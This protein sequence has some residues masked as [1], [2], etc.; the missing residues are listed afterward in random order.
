M[1][2]QHGAVSFKGAPLST[3]RNWQTSITS[4]LKTFVASNTKGGT[5]RRPGIFDWN[6]TFGQYGGVP[7]ALPGDAGAFIGYPGPEDGIV[8]SSG[9]CA[10]GPAMIQ[11]LSTTWNWVTDEIVSTVYNMVGTGPL[12]ANSALVQDASTPNTTRSSA[13]APW[14]FTPVGGAVQ[15]PCI[16]QATLN[17]LVN[18]KEFA[19]SCTGGFKSRTTGVIDW[20]LSLT[21][22]EADV[23]KL[24]GMTPGVFCAIKAFVNP[25]LFWQ[26]NYGLIGDFSNYNVNIETGDIITYNVNFSMASDNG[27]AV[28]VAGAITAPGGV[29]YWPASGAIV[30]EGAEE[31]LVDT[32][33]VPITE[34][35]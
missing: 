26:L 6:G 20:N 4:E 15:S 17:V 3:I 24:V 18:L 2:G 8:G 5:G 21:L 28:P 31:E 11:Q 19:N 16:Q 34:E 7:V 14:Q 13:C 10:E 23:T 27:A 35:E 32:E 1:S 29:A 30:A 25:T 9:P 12:I 33:G 22:D